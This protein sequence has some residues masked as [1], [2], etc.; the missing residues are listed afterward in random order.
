MILVTGG[1]GIAG[2]RLLEVLA[3]KGATI[4][5]SY[6]AE[7]S[8]SAPRFEHANIEW[9]EGDLKDESFCTQLCD[10]IDE[11][12]HCAAYRFTVAVHKS[13]AA[14]VKEENIAMSR[15]LTSALMNCKTLKLAVF[16]S[17]ANIGPSEDAAASTDGYI[18]GKAEAEKLWK[19]L[20]DAT[21]ID[22]LI[23]R[24]V[25]IY[26]P[27]DRFTK[28]S[29]VIP[30]LIVQASAGERVTIW[31][32]GSQER[33]F[34]YVDDLITAILTMQ[35]AGLTGTHY[36]SSPDTVTV[37]NLARTIA[38]LI[39]SNITIEC[40]MTKPS[41]KAVLEMQPNHTVLKGMKWTTLKQGLIATIESYKR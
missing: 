5:A 8:G 14:K 29:N 37:K 40:D 23:L 30:S 21:K 39:N 27:H 3:E 19:Q 16:M 9:T 24:S 41:G 26:G 20:A 10:G 18:A 15:A 25:P 28:D 12:Y 7:G 36:V 38:D 35:Q 22:L 2:R 1:T 32:D 6:R 33:S 34:I 13:E 17:T 4:R 11:V 31:G